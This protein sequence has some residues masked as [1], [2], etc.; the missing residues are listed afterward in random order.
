[1]SRRTHGPEP[2][3]D[4]LR[5]YPVMVRNHP[6]PASSL[7][8]SDPEGRPYP[9]VTARSLSIR[10]HAD[11]SAHTAPAHVLGASTPWRWHREQAIAI[12]KGSCA[13]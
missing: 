2:S 8:P 9:L 7:Q 4:H 1:M 10:C 5:E 13:T 3:T 6:W 12:T 11:A